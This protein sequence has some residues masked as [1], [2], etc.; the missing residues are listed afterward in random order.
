MKYKQYIRAGVYPLEAVLPYVISVRITR[1]LRKRGIKKNSPEWRS[2]TERNYDGHSVRM[3]SGR[4]RM[5]KKKGTT[6]ITCGFKGTYFALERH[7]KANHVKFHF[8]CYGKDKKGNERMITKD[9]IIPRALG[10]PDHLYNYQPMCD[11]CNA[12]KEDGYYTM[13]PI[14][15]MDDIERL[16]Y[17]LPPKIR[18]H[19]G[20]D[21]L[22]YRIASFL[23]RIDR[24]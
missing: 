23:H 24:L 6:C 3:C 20:K 2:V 10:G 16:I 17:G 1:F 9:H 18:R 11:R 19:A 21:S 12:E 14:S 8:N 7:K 15:I 13:D 5:F 4:Y 22:P